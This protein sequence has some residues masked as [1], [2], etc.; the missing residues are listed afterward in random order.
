MSIDGLAVVD[1][2]AGCT[3]HDVVGRCRR[4]FG[5]RKVGHGGTLDPDATGVLLVGL[6][7]A[8]RLLRYLSALPKSYEAEVVLGAATSTLDDSGEV[9]ATF[10]MS[11]V[12][13]DDVRA[14]AAGFVGEIDQI[15]PMVS[16]V[17][18]GGRRLHELARAGIEV[19]RPP[20]RVT[21]SRF[22]VTP[23]SE[24]GVFRIEV[25]CSSGT[26]VRS[27]A[28]D[29]GAALGGG[30]HLRRLRRT[31]V[32]RFTVD[33]ATSLDDLGAGD[34]LAPAAAVAHLT[35]VTVDGEVVEAVGYGRPLDLDWPGAGPWGV[36]DAGGRLLAV[37]E[38]AADG[39]ARPAVVLAPA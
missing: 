2:P 24:P 8:T 26:Y 34:V 1:K 5:Q 36:L 11:G 20:R 12:G 9:L 19:D 32:G 6:G 16:A 21:V 30:A 27:L 25:D 33:T 29:V 18:V 17:Q 7:R 22:D 35:P 13:L 10:D 28:A 14:A 15:P 31:A 3:S 39:R 38:P 4:I 23:G 37:Y